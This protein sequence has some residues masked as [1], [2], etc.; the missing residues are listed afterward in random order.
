MSWVR[1][2]VTGLLNRLKT[3]ASFW[4]PHG[5]AGFDVPGVGLL[6]SACIT[7]AERRPPAFEQHRDLEPG[8]A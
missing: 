4:V 2:D 7:A 5:V 6:I 1:Y 3:S 8:P